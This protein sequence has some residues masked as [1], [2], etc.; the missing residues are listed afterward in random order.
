MIILEVVISI[1]WTPFISM[2]EQIL[3]SKQPVVQLDVALFTG[4]KD[5]NTCLLFISSFYF[6]LCLR[7]HGHYCPWFLYSDIKLL[8][9]AEGLWHD[10]DWAAFPSL[11]RGR[12]VVLWCTEVQPVR[13]AACCFSDWNMVSNEGLLF[14]CIKSLICTGCEPGVHLSKMH[15]VFPCY[16]LMGLCRIISELSI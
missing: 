3:F 2:Q 16:R 4:H 9:P 8:S 6:H 7:R 10:L 5:L 12:P 13:N 11:F 1:D 15:I 14:S